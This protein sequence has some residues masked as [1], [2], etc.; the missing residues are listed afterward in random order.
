[1]KKLYAFVF[2]LALLAACKKDVDNK[3]I[4]DPKE[5]LQKISEAYALGGSTKVELWAKSNLSTGHNQ[6][7]IALYDSISNQIINKAEVKVLPVM[8]M[9]MN[10]MK[11]SHSAPCVQPE[12]D[13]AENTLFPFGTV[14]TMPGNTEQSKWS[15]EV[16]VKRD[17]Q[18]K[19]A[20]AK[21]GLKVGPSSPDRVKMLTTTDGDKLV[22]AC[23]FPGISKV[24]INELEMIVYRQ[25]DKMN[26]L[27]AEDYL[28]GITPEMPAMGHGSPNNINPVYTKNG[29]YKG[30]VNFT[31]TGDW[32]INLELVRGEQKSNTF[33]DLSF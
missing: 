26:F 20:K 27:P 17:G 31:M 32:R 2:L 10:G 29:V 22:V 3:N 33:F 4:T 16:T 30:K 13:R 23:F 25:R 11:M 14:F 21:L 19:T 5:G 28:L 12:N 1:M 15:F 6:L 7:F 9:E 8:D 18:A 24:G